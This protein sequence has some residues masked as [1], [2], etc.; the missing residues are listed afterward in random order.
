MPADKPTEEELARSRAK[1][2]A[3]FLLVVVIVVVFLA[4]ASRQNWSW[5]HI[6]EDTPTPA[7]SSQVGVRGVFVEPD[8]GHDPVVEELDAADGSIDVMIYLLSD[9]DVMN[10]LGRAENRG[11]DV[12]VILERDPFG[13]FG[14][15]EQTADA[16]RDL[17]A[18][19][20]WSDPEFTFTHAKTIVVDDETGLILNL[21]LTRS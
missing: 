13:G 6:A 17:G 7:S 19:V 14:D 5:I 16:L 21:N 10:A 2:K 20:H 4:F 9:R 11:V 3:V 1:I 15:P 8:D 18:E 12:R